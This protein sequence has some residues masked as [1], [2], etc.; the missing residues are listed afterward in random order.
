MNLDIGSSESILKAENSKTNTEDCEIISSLV[1]DLSLLKDNKIKKEF[2]KNLNPSQIDQ[3]TLEK[4]NFFNLSGPTKNHQLSKM[5]M[6]EIINLGNIKKLNKSNPTS[7]EKLKTSSIFST[8]FLNQQTSDKTKSRD[9]MSELNSNNSTDNECEDTNEINHTACSSYSTQFFKLDKLLTEKEN[10]SVHE[11]SGKQFLLKFEEGNLQNF[12]NPTFIH[13]KSK[14]FSELTNNSTLI[15][16]KQSMNNLFLKVNDKLSI[17]VPKSN[18]K[19]SKLLTPSWK[20]KVDL[21]KFKNFISF[22]ILLKIKYSQGDEKHNKKLSLPNKLMLSFLSKHSQP[23][24]KEL[25]SRVPIKIP[26]P[27]CH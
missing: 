17:Y 10:H 11:K 16:S 9:K 21:I 20:E 27:V 14:I 19:F 8:M 7:H 13:Q 2:M 18:N 4:E 12:P 23:I 5:S 3:N 15:T 22:L 6:K 25:A 24:M 26:L 1:K